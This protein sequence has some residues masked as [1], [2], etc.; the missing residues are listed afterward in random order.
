MGIGSQNNWEDGE[1]KSQALQRQEEGVCGGSPGFCI[2]QNLGS[3]FMLSLLDKPLSLREGRGERLYREEYMRAEPE[4]R[5]L[6]D[7]SLSVHNR[8]SKLEVG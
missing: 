4:Q 2:T 8:E 7:H 5:R 3:W 6:A 1:S